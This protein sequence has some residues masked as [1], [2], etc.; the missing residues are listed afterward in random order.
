[1]IK[2]KIYFLTILMTSLAF[3]CVTQK[4]CLQKFPPSMDTLKIIQTK[5]S[6]VFKDKP[7]YFYIK[8]DTI[9]DSIFI[10]VIVDRPLNSDTI[11]K[12][13]S[14]AIAHAWVK[15]NF[16][17]LVLMQKDTTI[18]TN[19]EN[20]IKE[21]YYWKSEYEKVTEITQPVKYIPPIYKKALW[22]CIGLIVLLIAWGAWKIFKILNLKK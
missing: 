15:R 17:N 18:E 2:F 13:T 7:V 11:I 8:G 6:I 12:E 5:D 10:E 14:L 1:M 20:A 19:L 22:V 3:S 4:K 9:R 21:A 16:L